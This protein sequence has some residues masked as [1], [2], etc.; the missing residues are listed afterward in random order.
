MRIGTTEDSTSL[1][2]KV[3]KQALE[4]VMIAE[5][6]VFLKENGG[7]KND[8]YERNIDTALG[9]LENLKIS[10]DKEGNFRAKLIEPYKRKDIG[11]EVR[12][13]AQA[14]ESVFEVN[15]GNKQIETGDTQEEILNHNSRW[16][17]SFSEKKHN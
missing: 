13:V 8:F 7:I 15:R 10:R 4:T 6:E 2:K 12:S 17:A 3:V 14:L 1:T 16:H 9:K 11:L 5:R